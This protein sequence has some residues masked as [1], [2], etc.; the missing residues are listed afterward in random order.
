MLEVHDSLCLWICFCCCAV[1]HSTGTPLPGFQGVI[2]RERPAVLLGQG[3]RVSAEEVLPSLFGPQLVDS[4]HHLR[5]CV[6]ELA[7]EHPV[8][9]QVGL[10]ENRPV[11]CLVDDGEPMRGSGQDVYRR[12]LAQGTAPQGLPQGPVPTTTPCTRYGTEVDAWGSDRFSDCRFQ[13]RHVRLV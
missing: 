8:A 4:V 11:S 2:V 12:L 1:N 5:W 3:G 10:E 13:P 7:A 6:V 9:S